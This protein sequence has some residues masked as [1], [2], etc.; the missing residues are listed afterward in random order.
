M[1]KKYFMFTINNMISPNS[2]GG[3]DILNQNLQATLESFK[4]HYPH[5]KNIRLQHSSRRGWSGVG[6]GFLVEVDV[7][8]EYEEE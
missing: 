3:G 2:F 1:E 4:K 7:L 6:S 8:V 5:A